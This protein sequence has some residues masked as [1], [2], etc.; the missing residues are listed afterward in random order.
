MV[1][2]ERATMDTVPQTTN[3]NLQMWTA[4][5]GKGFTY[6]INY[7]TGHVT[8]MGGSTNVSDASLKSTPEDASTEDCLQMLRQVNAR[9]YSRLDL[10]PSKSHIGFIAREVRDASPPAFGGLLSSCLHSD[11]QGGTEREILT[12]DYSRLTAV[13]WQ[14]CR[15]LLA[16]V[17][18][19]EARLE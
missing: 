17:E 3:S 19:L 14:S 18:A 11:S 13:L 15:S 12:L 4:N 8:F 6:E 16:R 10:E 5:G 1:L 9:T 7:G 2:T